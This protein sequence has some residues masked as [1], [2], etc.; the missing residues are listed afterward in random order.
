MSARGRMIKE[1]EMQKGANYDEWGEYS[2]W[3]SIPKEDGTFKHIGRQSK[4]Q[5]SR[6]CKRCHKR[7]STECRHA[8]ICKSCY[9]GNYQGRRQVPRGGE[10]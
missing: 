4:G 2:M 5:Y 7:F 10:R 6:E 9:K 8:R 1:R 3:Q